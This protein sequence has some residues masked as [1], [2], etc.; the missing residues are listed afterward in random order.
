MYG[1]ETQKLKHLPLVCAKQNKNG[2]KKNI[3]FMNWW[4]LTRMGSVQSARNN[5][6]FIEFQ[7]IQQSDKISPPYLIFSTTNMQ[8]KTGPVL[9]GLQKPTDITPKK[10][11]TSN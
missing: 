1:S 8:N 9:N 4:I 5:I 6:Q 11:R 7:L 10:M 2:N 3:G